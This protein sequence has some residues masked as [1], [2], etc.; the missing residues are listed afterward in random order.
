M[1]AGVEWLGAGGREELVQL[2]TYVL[3]VNPNPHLYLLCT[4]LSVAFRVSGMSQ[5]RKSGRGAGQGE[6]VVR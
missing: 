3:E 5:R 6:A 2:K 4:T 1:V